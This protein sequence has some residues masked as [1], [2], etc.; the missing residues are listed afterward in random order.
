[1]NRFHAL[2]S[3]V[4]LAAMALGACAQMPESVAALN[5]HDDWGDRGSQVRA[6]DHEQ[7][8]R[9]LENMRAQMAGCM[10]GRGWRVRE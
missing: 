9:L 7:C 3:V 4:V 6:R 1:V 5:W 2:R 8:A 10:A